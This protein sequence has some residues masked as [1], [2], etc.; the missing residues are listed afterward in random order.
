M[1]R[2][3]RSLSQ[4]FLVDPNLQRKIVETL[5]AD[6][7]TGVL[8]I[9]PGHGELTR[10]L[11]GR[12]RSVLAVEKDDRLA[13]ELAEAW[14]DRDDV[15]VIHGDA[16]ELDLSA[17][18]AR[19]WTAGVSPY[20]V[21]SN[22]PYA[23]TSPLT[24][25]LLDL[26]PAPGRIVLTVQ[27][28]VAERMAAEP[29]GGDFG[30]LSVGVQIRARVEVAFGVSRAAFRPPP[31]VDS[32]TVVLV[33]RP[34]APP[35]GEMRGIRRL[36]RAAFGRRRKQLQKILRSAPEFGCSR[37]EAEALCAELGVDP[38]TRPEKLAPAQFRALAA[39][40]ASEGAAGP[41]TL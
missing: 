13:S 28:E 38:R 39:L 40:L 15:E 31:D 33:P 3:K 32:A 30:A 23:I 36:T 18:L 19:S 1:R 7:E 2:A 5:E 14:A 16:L 17:L 29:G 21:L 20:V 22:V 24:F 10:H 12:V 8:E 4:N 25:R 6:P 41:D 9:G 35:P 27:R 37:E 26:E 34:G 11:V